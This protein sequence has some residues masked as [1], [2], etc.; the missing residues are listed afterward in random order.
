MNVPWQVSYIVQHMTRIFQRGHR[1]HSEQRLSTA[2]LDNFP[3]IMSPVI[4][5]GTSLHRTS[6]QGKSYSRRGPGDR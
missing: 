5:V 4:V 2:A 1:I 3:A 6:F